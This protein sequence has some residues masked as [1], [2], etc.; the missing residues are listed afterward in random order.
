M[1]HHTSSD[2]GVQT[3]ARTGLIS[4][5]RSILAC[6]CLCLLLVLITQD[7][8]RSPNTYLT[9]APADNAGDPP[10]R[11]PT[12]LAL[13]DRGD[14]NPAT[15][16]GQQVSGTDRGSTGSA[17]D[18]PADLE[19]CQ[20]S[21]SK[22][23]RQP[24][25]QAPPVN[26]DRQSKEVCGLQPEEE[27]RMEMA[28]P[29]PLPRLNPPPDSD[30][31]TAMQD[32]LELRERFGSGMGDSQDFAAAMEELLSPDS[33]VDP[34]PSVRPTQAVQS[35]DGWLSPAKDPA[36]SPH[37]IQPQDAGY[38]G[39]PHFPNPWPVMSWPGQPGQPGPQGPVPGQPHSHP[40]QAGRAHAHGAQP[41]AANPGSN[42]PAAAWLPGPG[43]PDIGQPNLPQPRPPQPW[44]VQAGPGPTDSH[45]PWPQPGH[46]MAA[47]PQTT[48]LNFNTMTAAPYV[49]YPI[50]NGAR[51]QDNRAREDQVQR[52]RKA[53]RALEDVAWLLEEAAEYSAAD[54]LRQQ[55]QQLYH[56]AR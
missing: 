16:D 36:G 35:A 38:P 56:R 30:M 9:M 17:D 40:S 24:G 3:P 12:V 22:P 7:Q 32:L 21:D 37:R 34:G 28:L 10:K 45:H 52:I 6:V 13:V 51:P 42:Q 5:I 43:Q 2:P 31:H 47:Q 19:T 48:A 26:V 29:V 11:T 53:A 14:E 1:D 33:A 54:H 27:H 8:T 18:C 23:H 20:D 50:P 15:D 4:A 55:A 49:P 39:Q 41:W 25:R 46:R 44:P